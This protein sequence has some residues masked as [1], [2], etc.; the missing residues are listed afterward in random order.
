MKE[1]EISSFYLPNSNLSEKEEKNSPK[2]V[3][4]KFNKAITNL[5]IQPLG[6]TTLMD[7]PGTRLYY[8][9][10]VIYLL[11]DIPYNLGVYL[12]KLDLAAKTIKGE[13]YFVNTYE[14]N[15]STVISKHK[16]STC[17]L[18]DSLLIIK[19]SSD[20][21][22][23]YSFF[24][25]KDGSLIRRYSATAQNIEKLAHSGLRQK[26]TWGSAKEEKKFDSNKKYLRKSSNGIIYIAST[27]S[28]SI[29][30]TNLSLIET[31]GVGGTLLDV[32][33][34]LSLEAHGV[35]IY[36]TSLLP[37]LGPSRD[38]IIY[39]H[40]RFSKKDLQPSLNTNVTTIVDDLLDDKKI[41]NLSAY[42][43]FVVKKNSVYFIGFYSK[44]LQ[45]MEVFKYNG[46]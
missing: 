39:F 45:K 20:K 26:G 6:E 7:R 23:E 44:E 42:S 12:M 35:P 17:L 2:E 37:P 19:N 18:L 46:E 38:K 14:D 43:S 15:G 28:D 11:M 4:I 25:I 3:R 10:N 41:E 13:N 31:T 36:L 21:I 22:L 5:A 16:E 34:P 33:V 9:S 24:N 30:I 29:T 1:P 27:G 40:T 32:F 8:D